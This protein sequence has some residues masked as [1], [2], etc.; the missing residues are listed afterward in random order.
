MNISDLTEH[1]I[2]IHGDFTLKSGQQSK[3]YVNMKNAISI[4]SLM[5]KIMI[6]FKRQLGNIDATNTVIC[7]VPDGAVPYAS[8]LSYETG[9]PLIMIRKEKKEYGTKKLIEGLYSVG[10]K[11]IL[12]ED[13]ITSGTSMIQCAK[14]LESEGL[15]VIRMLSIV[16]R[17]VGIF[18]DSANPEYKNITIESLIKISDYSRCSIMKSI[19]A[20]K[21]PL[22]VAAD[23]TSTSEL[24]E[25][26]ERIGPEISIL[27][28][29]VDIISDFTDETIFHIKRLKMK[30]RFVVWEDRKFADIGAVAKE[31]IHGGIYKISSWA[32][33]ISM[34]VISGPDILDQAGDC[35][36]I[37]I[38][39]MSSNKTL[40]DEAY[41]RKCLEFISE[42]K[43]TNILGI[44]TQNN[45]DCDHNLLKIVPG[46]N[47]SQKETD[48]LGQKYSNIENKKW[49]D[50]F[51]VGRD[52]VRN[53]NPYL[54]TLEYKEYIKKSI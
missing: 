10:T 49:A 51:V 17:F 29:H 45:V 1:G 52:I 36:V 5:K 9:I 8:M 42:S 37:V 27:K 18:P 26:V 6:G 20:R 32:D 54:K 30:H 4:P 44:V 53:R 24:I 11:V 35:G 31:Q 2:I 43:N 16:S 7:G 15:E 3:Y 25:L 28:M 12:I 40:A 23:V 22:C 46:I 33:L 39:S 21:G 14:K 13:V 41:E 38:T 19:M 47:I 34:H 48:N 50:I